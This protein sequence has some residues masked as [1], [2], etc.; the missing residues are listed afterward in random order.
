MEILWYIGFGSLLGIIIQHYLNRSTLASERIYQYQKEEL[1]RYREIAEKIIE[2]LILLHGHRELFFHY[3]QLSYD[4]SIR[5]WSKFSDLND[6]LDK[7]DFDKNIEQIATIIFLYFPE[8]SIDW[9]DCLDNI[10]QV[11]TI[12]HKIKLSDH[13]L[14]KNDWKLAIDEFNKFAQLLWDKPLQISQSIKDS[15]SK[16]EAAIIEQ[17]TTF[18]LF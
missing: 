5:L 11:A 1:L 3:I 18:Y 7:S 16:R 17:K 2:K 15:I 8:L 9:N 13:Q 10:S 14:S 12:I 4:A 6:S